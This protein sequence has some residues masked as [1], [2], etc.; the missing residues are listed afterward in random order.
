MY[1][2]IIY[3]MSQ[4]HDPAGFSETIIIFTLENI[5]AEIALKISPIHSFYRRPVDDHV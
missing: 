4:F 3:R 1:I 5:G 2:I